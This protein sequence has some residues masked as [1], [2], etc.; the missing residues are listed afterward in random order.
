M[1]ASSVHSILNTW[2]LSTVQEDGCIQEKMV[3][4]RKDSLESLSNDAC[5]LVY[6]FHF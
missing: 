2:I 3:D 4:S 5:G 1:S 6:L